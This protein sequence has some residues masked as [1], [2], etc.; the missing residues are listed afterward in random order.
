MRAIKIVCGC[1][2]AVAIAA[3]LVQKNA[4]SS[5]RAENQ[6]L[7]QRAQQATQLAGENERIAGLRVEN[8]EVELLIT[9]NRDL[10]KLRNEVRQLRE[11]RPEIDRLRRENQRLA[12]SL[13][14]GTPPPA[15]L[16][17]VE[18][19][20][21]NEKWTYDLGTPEATIQTWFLAMREGN[22][23]QFNG[24]LSPAMQ[25]QFERQFRNMTDEQRSAELK[26]RPGRIARIPGYQIA[27]REEIAEDLVVLGIRA[28]LN[29][30][31]MKI[32]LRRYGNEWKIDG[33]LK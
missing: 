1:L 32:Q 17:N 20:V 19:Y 4:I 23:Q 16:A 29:G 31:V 9:A 27:A 24:A 28:A 6:N 15:S 14:T 33:D 8:Q 2:L 10:P 22:W 3:V 21:P 18:G 7:H 11:Q 30:E 26:E 13:A 12:A 5:L 25:K